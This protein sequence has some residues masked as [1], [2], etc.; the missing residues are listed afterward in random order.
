[1]LAIIQSDPLPVIRLHEQFHFHSFK[2]ANVPWWFHNLAVAVISQELKT[3]IFSVIS[4][5]D[6]QSTT[7][8]HSWRCHRASQTILPWCMIF[9]VAFSLPHDWLWRA[10]VE[11][12]EI[13]IFFRIRGRSHWTVLRQKMHA[14]AQHECYGI[15]QALT[16]YSLWQLMQE[17][18]H[19][20]VS[21][22]NENSFDWTPSHLVPLFIYLLVWLSESSAPDRFVLPGP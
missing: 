22:N 8:F 6:S 20:M 11:S 2:A 14:T 17:S 3:W 5:S 10:H 15:N 19:F 21:K 7:D 12:Q 13:I 9:T 1:M 4:Y 18:Q 16:D